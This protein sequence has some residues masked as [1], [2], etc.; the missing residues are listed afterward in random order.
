MEQ[1]V[2][3]RGGPAGDTRDE[4]DALTPI[5]RIEALARSKRWMYF[6]VRNT[7][8]HRAQAKAYYL[9]AE[10]LADKGGDDEELCRKIMENLTYGDWT[11][12]KRESLWDVVAKKERKAFGEVED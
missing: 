9:V 7:L 1:R 5:Q 6:E 3:T 11:K 10:R 8:K 4:L 12:G 2:F